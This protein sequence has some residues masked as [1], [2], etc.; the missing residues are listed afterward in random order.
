MRRR[1]LARDL[2]GT[3]LM[4]LLLAALTFGIIMFDNLVLEAFKAH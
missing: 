2:I 4:F 1:S 3:L